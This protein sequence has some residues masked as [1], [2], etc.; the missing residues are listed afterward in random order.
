MVRRQLQHD[1]KCEI[2]GTIFRHVFVPGK[3]FGDIGN[4]ADFR[5]PDCK[6]KRRVAG[7]AVSRPVDRDSR[8]SVGNR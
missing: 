3:C 6:K 5:C 2:C 7:G 8:A 4:A 1:R